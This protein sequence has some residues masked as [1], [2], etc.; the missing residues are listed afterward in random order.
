MK[1]KNARRKQKNNALSKTKRWVDKAFKWGEYLLP[2]AEL[3]LS[4]V[5]KR[6]PLY[7]NLTEFISE[8]RAVVEQNLPIAKLKL[9]VV[10]TFSNVAG[11]N[12]KGTITMDPSASNDWTSLAAL[13]DEFRVVAIRSTFNPGYQAGDQPSA[14][15]SYPPLYV[16]YNDRATLSPTVAVVV[17]YQ[18]MVVIGPA[19]VFGSH[20]VYEAIRPMSGDATAVQWYPTSSPGSSPGGIIFSSTPN[21]TNSYTQL[22]VLTEFHVEFRIRA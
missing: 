11:A 22:E 16:A 3:L 4:G 20:N 17:N 12:V 18:N 9:R 6:Q 7:R 8:E 19:H 21:F 5:L 10:D 2:L 14:K 13:Y 15:N 1:G